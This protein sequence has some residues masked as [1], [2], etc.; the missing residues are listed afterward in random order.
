M[1]EDV[2]LEFARWLSPMFAIW[3]NDRI[4]ELLTKGH[5]EIH[6]IPE[7][8]EP[9]LTST[10]DISSLTGRPHDRIMKDIRKILEQGAGNTSHTT[11]RP[12]DC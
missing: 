2:A 10:F 4:K 6:Q 9:V 1:H 8:S 3:C 11:S 7:P 12:K 5:T